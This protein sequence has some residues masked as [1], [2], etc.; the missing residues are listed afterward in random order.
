MPPLLLSILNFSSKLIK[1]I[2]L[3]SQSSLCCPAASPVKL[4]NHSGIGG[5]ETFGKSRTVRK[6][7]VHSELI[8]VKC[9]NVTLCLEWWLLSDLTWWLMVDVSGDLLAERAQPACRGWLT[10]VSAWLWG[11]AM[12]C[13]SRL[14]RTSTSTR[15]SPPT[16]VRVWRCSPGAGTGPVWP[17]PTW[18]ASRSRGSARGSGTLSPIF[19]RPRYST[20]VQSVLS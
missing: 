7:I 11:G 17:G 9:R 13:V 18:P 19:H 20:L 2:L 1:N 15:A 6:M 12:E 14:L 4:E 5:W 16:P 3:T 10:A 8:F